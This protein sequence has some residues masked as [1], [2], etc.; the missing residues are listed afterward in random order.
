M[1]PPPSEQT[2]F[3]FSVR[4]KSSTELAR[5][6]HPLRARLQK[7]E[8]EHKKL[9][10]SIAR[11]RAK[12]EVSA[13]LHE[14]ASE[15]LANTMF[16]LRQR[17]VQ[18]ITRIRKL[19]EPLVGPE[20]KLSK[21]DR[22]RVASVL[23]EILEALPADEL[24]H[25]ETDEPPPDGSAWGF[26]WDCDDAGGPMPAESGYSAPKPDGKHVSL[27]ALFK[28]LAVAAHPDRVLDEQEKLERTQVMSEVTQ[29]Y[30]RGDIAR[31]LELERSWLSREELRRDDAD[32]LLRQL[33]RLEATNKEL[34]RQLR[35]LQRED[36]DLRDGPGRVAADG[37]VR[38]HPEVQLMVDNTETV[39][40]DLE[41][42]RKFTERFARGELSVAEFLEGPELDD[43]FAEELETLTAIA[44]NDELFETI[45]ADLA[46][47]APRAQRGPARKKK[48]K[49][50]GGK[51]KR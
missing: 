49:K 48:A 40:G 30:E 39:V 44:G 1:A 19:L 23:R 50:K 33:E 47:E 8:A 26:E 28:R 25:D 22:K 35:E 24:G 51:K 41:E 18:A 17:A 32:A 12:V 9:L 29:A 34:R 5:H 3:D 43:E 31:L 11:K 27:K 38:F 14:R 46:A 45:M 6:V 42:F 10:A 4:E 2:S 36:R 37:E 21:R 15:Q 13:E 16:A 20:S 7:L